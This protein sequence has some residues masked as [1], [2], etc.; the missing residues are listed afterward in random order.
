MSYHSLKPL[1]KFFHSMNLE[2][3]DFDL[4]EAQGGSIRVFVSHEGSYK[5]KKNKIMRQIKIE[6]KQ[7]LFTKQK[8]LNFYK[9]I[10]NQKEK[11]KKLINKN[12]NKKKLIVGYGA[13]AKV[14]TFCHVFNIGNNEIK[15]IV[16]DNDLKQNKFTPGKNIKIINFNRLKNINFD[17]III[18]AWNFAKP[19]TKKL[20]ENIKNKK[21][22]IIIPFPKL[23]VI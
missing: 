15:Y 3:V 10:K 2:V 7:G 21:F 16:D 9:R 6:K 5:V 17:Y 8:Y 18:L 22:K 11:I 12:L 14:T 1:I 20:K 13:P 23:K 4:I 19:I